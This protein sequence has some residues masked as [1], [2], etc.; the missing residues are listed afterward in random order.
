MA[1]T[2]RGTYRFTV[3]EI[4]RGT[5]FLWSLGGGLIR[6]GRG[7]YRSAQRGQCTKSGLIFASNY[8]CRKRISTLSR[9]ARG[10]ASIRQATCGPAFRSRDICRPR[11]PTRACVYP[12]VPLN[13]AQI[14]QQL[15]WPRQQAARSTPEIE[16]PLPASI[17]TSGRRSFRNWRAIVSAASKFGTG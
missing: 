11:L 1:T 13:D 14:G 16:L 6:Q 10:S 8:F 4:G 12:S 2:E 3:K 9:A 17:V 5:F 15:L 7:D